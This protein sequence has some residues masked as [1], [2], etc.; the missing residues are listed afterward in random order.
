MSE[1]EGMKNGFALGNVVQLKS[2]GPPMTVIRRDLLRH[3]LSQDFYDAYDVGWFDGDGYKTIL[4]L[5]GATLTVVYIPRKE[6]EDPADI[7]SLT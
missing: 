1:G 7:L 3:P 4:G 5:A 6:K 2:G